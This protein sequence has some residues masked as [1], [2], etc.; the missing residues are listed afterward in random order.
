MGIV[1]WYESFISVPLMHLRFLGATFVIA[2]TSSPDTT[3]SYNDLLGFDFTILFDVEMLIGLENTDFV[4]WELDTASVRGYSPYVA[5]GMS[6]VKPLIRVN[7][8]L[9][10][11]PSDFALSLAFCSSSGG[12]SSLSVILITFVRPSNRQNSLIWCLRY[13]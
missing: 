2:H 10:S 13:R 1:V 6:Y 5:E 12:A 8:C 7:S 9:M 3:P 4:V 11:P